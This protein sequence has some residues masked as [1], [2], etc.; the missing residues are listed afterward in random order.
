MVEEPIYFSLSADK[1]I[2]EIIPNKTTFYPAFPREAI[3]ENI[4]EANTIVRIGYRRER[5]GQYRNVS[6]GEREGDA[7]QIAGHV[8]VIVGTSTTVEALDNPKNLRTLSKF[9]LEAL[10]RG[11]SL[12]GK[13]SVGAAPDAILMGERIHADQVGELP[14]SKEIIQ[15]LQ[16]Y[17]LFSERGLRKQ[18]TTGT[19]KNL[20]AR[21]RAMSETDR[22]RFLGAIWPAWLLLI[23]IMSVLLK[24]STF[25]SNLGLP[26]M[27]IV[28]FGTPFVVFKQLYNRMGNPLKIHWL[29]WGS[30]AV[31]FPPAAWV[32]VFIWKEGRVTFD[33]PKSSANRR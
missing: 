6:S 2:N 23:F 33:P 14:S 20:S 26:I 16:Q 31:F 18:G 4:D 11:I 3:T 30:I 13:D 8:H 9:L 21:F 17:T 29:L 12:G 7:Y 19:P 24:S 5:I 32:A 15:Y 28:Y 25:C 27:F 1:S 10:L 22:W